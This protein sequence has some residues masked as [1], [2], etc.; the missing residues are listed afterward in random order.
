MVTL[1]SAKV[2]VSD[3]IC[4][5]GF[6]CYL[7]SRS[8]G[9][10]GEESPIVPGSSTVGIGLKAFFQISLSDSVDEDDSWSHLSDF[11]DRV[12]EPQ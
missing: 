4:T 5:N 7:P 12:G 10:S 3:M 2:D 11:S 1:N 6:T 9:L 8:V